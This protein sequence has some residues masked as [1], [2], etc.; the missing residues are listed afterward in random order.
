MDCRARPQATKA[1]RGRGQNLEDFLANFP[2]ADD[3]QENLMVLAFAHLPVSTCICRLYSRLAVSI[4]A[5]KRVASASKLQLSEINWECGAFQ[6][7][8][9]YAAHQVTRR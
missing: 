7:S 4:D 8:G 3:A 5:V 6:E 2:Y 1:K 9:S